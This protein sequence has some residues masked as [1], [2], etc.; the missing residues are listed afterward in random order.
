MKKYILFISVLV[1]LCI[2]KSYGQQ[3]ETQGFRAAAGQSII[4]PPMGTYMVEPQAARAAGVHDDLYLRLVVMEAG[5][6]AVVIVSYDLVGLDLAFAGRIRQ[7]INEETGIPA[8]NIMLNCTH[9]HNVPI[10]LDLGGDRSK[11]NREW[12]KVLQEKTVA[13]I[14]KAYGRLKPATMSV[15]SDSVQ[16]AFNRRLMMFNRAKMRPNPFGPVV[17]QVQAVKIEIGQGSS[18]VLFTYPAHP[19]AVHAESAEF[20]ADFPGFAI[21]AIREEMG[22]NTIPVF[23]QGCAGDINV[24]PLRGGYE[25]AAQVGNSLGKS[26][27]DA[28]AQPE[29]VRVKKVAT[30]SEKFFLPYRPIRP[31]VAEKVVL[32]VEEG[33]AALQAADADTIEILD[34]QDVLH[35]AR[36]LHHIAENP[37]KNPG[38]P[39]E[40]QVFAFNKDFAMIAFTHELFVEY[41]LYIQ[42]NSPFKHTLVLAYTNGNAAYVPTA[43]AF[44]LNGY[45]VHG[46]QHRYG[47]PYLSPESDEMI[48]EKALSVLNA[49]YTQYERKR[50]D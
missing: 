19:V 29:S 47:S 7:A 5:D 40:M 35:W 33:M 23:L 36:R 16:V 27:L 15:G 11:R 34:Q 14:A 44:Y 9:A 8:E 18:A 31:E 50:I 4:T 42:E 24:D 48:K 45:E 32:R 46:A 1:L 3:I 22:P 30:A 21:E 17:K 25:A 6:E 2:I 41:Q 10:S 38:L 20:T 49:L 39:F 12:E 26:V 43:D 28:L 37:D 13:T